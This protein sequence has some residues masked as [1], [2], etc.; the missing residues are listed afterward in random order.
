M[1]LLKDKMSRQIVAG[2]ARDALK[3]I[4]SEAAGGENPQ[5]GYEKRGEESYGV[6]QVASGKEDSCQHGG[7]Q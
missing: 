5:E 6:F 7:G 2:I 4:S 3:A 1:S